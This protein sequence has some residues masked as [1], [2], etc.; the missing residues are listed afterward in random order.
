MDSLQ[1]IGFSSP[2]LLAL[3]LPLL[4]VIYLQL[5]N[6]QNSRTI[7]LTGLEYLRVGAGVGGRRR[8]RASA[9][10]WTLLVLLVGLLWA[11]PVIQ[12]ARP[13]FDGGEQTR[14]KD[15]LIAM[16][17]SPSMSVPLAQT[18]Q[19]TRGGSSSRQVIVKMGK[20][21]GPTRFQAA[22]ETLM[23]FLQRF[24]GERIGLIMFS[25]EPFLARWPTTDIST[26]FIEVL[27]EDIGRGK[28]TQLQ[29]FS[30]LTNL[31]FA[32]DLARETFAKQDGLKGG[33][34]IVI[35]DAEDDMENMVQGAERVRAAGI[36][37]YT[38][39][40]GISQRIA[41]GL[42]RHFA[43]D[44]GFRIFRVE[45]REEMEEAYRLIAE[46]EESPLFLAE[47]GYRTEVRWA[48]A[49]AA[50]LIAAL[51]LWLLEV[52]FHQSRVADPEI[53]PAERRHGLRFS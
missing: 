40:V 8:R 33:A 39:A 15:F 19:V 26:R 3:I 9:A 41:D 32:L 28:R 23:N 10:L 44:P 46:V 5:K 21:E 50:G 4:G 53:A 7:V 43:G 38:I 14:H 24:E 25:T 34:V 6:R 16:D 47:T 52:G 42:T 29:A 20:A 49:L 37:L 36:R 22:R 45:S 13:L 2:A 51:V 31:H 18:R 11:G 35:S 1:S 48:L 17:L 30:S 27:E 12:T